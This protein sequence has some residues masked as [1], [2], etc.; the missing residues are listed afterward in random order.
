MKEL[1]RPSHPVRLN[2]RISIIVLPFMLLEK[3]LLEV[4]YV[5]KGQRYLGCF[6][7]ISP[8]PLFLKESRL[9]GRDHRLS[10][11]YAN[12]VLHSKPYYFFLAHS[13]LVFPTITPTLAKFT[14]KGVP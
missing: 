5:C 7:G 3:I 10:L 2:Y 14:E 8:P 4:K 1:N 12:E 13:Y 6:H 11:R 9:R